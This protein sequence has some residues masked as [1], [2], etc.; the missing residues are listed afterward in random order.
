MPCYIKLFQ[1]MEVEVNSESEIA[2]LRARIDAEVMALQRLKYG[3]A[4]IASH[5]MITRRFQTL[6]DCFEALAEHVGEEA[7]I[8]AISARLDQAL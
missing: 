8:E 1:Y 7:A 5:E 2:L 6:G 3:F 4:A